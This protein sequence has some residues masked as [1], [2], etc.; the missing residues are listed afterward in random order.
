MIDAIRII[1][2][3][4]ISEAIEE[5]L[6]NIEAWYNK[7]LPK[8]NDS[9]IPNDLRMA[10]KILK[11]AGYVPPEIETRKEIQKLE[12]LIAASEDE[13]T[14]V[15]QIKKLNYLEMKLDAMRGKSAFLE[16]QE[17][18]Y[19]KVVERLSVAKKR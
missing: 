1:A 8:S 7:P 14:R 3:R 12:D 2:E 6:L 4:K 19:Q 5:G 10:Y 16:N 9:L 13:H 15:K 11:N 17:K 18:Y